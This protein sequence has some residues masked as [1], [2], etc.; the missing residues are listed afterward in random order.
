MRPSWGT[1][2]KGAWA[3]ENFARE[4]HFEQ[5]RAAAGRVTHVLGLDSDD[6]IVVGALKNLGEARHVHANAHVAVA[7]VVLE[8]VGLELHRHQRH[9]GRVHC[10]QGDACGRAVEVGLGHEVLDG[11]DELLEKRSLGNASL[12]AWKTR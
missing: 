8:A 6:V 4:R 9:V 2:K 11:L 1:A 12:N 3:F 10:L 7:S 5:G